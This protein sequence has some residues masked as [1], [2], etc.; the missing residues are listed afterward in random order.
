MKKKGKEIKM[1]KSYNK[2]NVVSGTVNSKNPRS[3]YINIAAWG[4]PINKEALNYANVIRGLNKRIKKHIFDNVLEPFNRNR[5]IIDLDMRESGILYGKRSF[6]SCEITLFQNKDRLLTT[7]ELKE[8][9]VEIT[10][11]VIED[12][13]DQNEYFEFYQK[14]N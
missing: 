7:D 10:D 12:V 3:V 11:N 1:G 8:T 9:I 2:Y 6:M 14:K 5:T 4:E 13:F